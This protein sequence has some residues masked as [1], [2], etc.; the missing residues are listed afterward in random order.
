V[1]GG[2]A[3]LDEAR[4]P[5]LVEHNGNR[6]AFLGC[7]PAGPANIWART[8]APGP[9]PCD[10]P[11]LEAEIGALRAKGI[12]PIVTLQAVEADTYT[13][14]PAQGAPNFR[15]LARAGAVI[16]SGSQ[17]HVPQVMTFVEAE[18]GHS[19][20]HY[21]LGNLFF[22]QMDPVETRQ[23]FI[24]RHTFYQGKYLG[25]ELRTALLEDY[26]RPRPMNEAERREFLE[27]IFSLSRWNEE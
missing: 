14:P 20:V 23:Q 26:A 16:V 17:S 1:Y 10:F 13:P 2:G 3:N 8:D 27:K 11:Q 25:V 22:D 24:D 19:F 5:L 21:G 6:L 12:L 15:R 18:Q 7:S 9:A 4:A